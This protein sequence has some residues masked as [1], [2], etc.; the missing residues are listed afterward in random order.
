MWI[1]THAHLSDEA[2]ELKL[3]E[4]LLR[5]KQASVDRMICVGTKLRS[6][7]ACIEL[8]EKHSQLFASVGVHPNYAHQATESEWKVIEQLLVHERVVAVGE[9]GLDK[10]WDDCPWET[11][12][13]SFTRQIE[14]SCRFQKPLIIHTRN[15]EA[16]MVEVLENESKNQSVQGVMH[17]FAGSLETAQRCLELGMYISF[18]GMLTYKKSEELRKV[19]SQIPI[20]RLLVE[21][22]CPYLSPEP[23]RSTRPNEPSLIVFTAQCLANC[24]SLSV[25][26]LAKATTEN[27][28]R[29]FHLPE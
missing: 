14:L 24:K 11:Q 28:K 3:E 5:A 1:D 25:N 27:A 9:T 20:D 17:S 10:Y 22:D 23:K 26:E 21:T 19:A 13:E 7:K 4:V 12:V 29:L 18:A 16:E 2:F 15:C 8:A 6:S